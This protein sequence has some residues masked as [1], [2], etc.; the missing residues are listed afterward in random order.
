MKLV[1]GKSGIRGSSAASLEEPFRHGRQAQ[2]LTIYTGLPDL[3]NPN[4]V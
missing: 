2:L 3:G 4:H 1:S